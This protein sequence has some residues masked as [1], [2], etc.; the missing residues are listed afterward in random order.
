MAWVASTDKELADRQRA[1]L[2][3]ERDR[4]DAEER[5]GQSTRD[6]REFG[7]QGARGGDNDAG[8]RNLFIVENIIQCQ[9]FHLIC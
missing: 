2:R 3:D 6:A 4:D 7:S 8:I 9:D 1:A 5:G